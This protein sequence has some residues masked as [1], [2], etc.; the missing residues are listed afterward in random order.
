MAL[1]HMGI[2]V[3]FTVAQGTARVECVADSKRDYDP[4]TDFYKGLRER[5][6]KQFVGGWD[7]QEFR[8]LVREVKTPNKQASYETCRA[9]LT[10]WAQNKDITAS[11][12]PNRN[13]EAAGLQVRV[14]P[15]L[16][17]TIDEKKYVVKLYFKADELTAS[18][19]ENALYLLAETAPQGVDAAILDIR[20]RKL[21]IAG[22]PD[23]N[24]DALLV[25]DAAA[26]AT[27]LG[28]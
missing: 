5:T 10:K 21:L 22:E 24:L 1:V 25:S 4:R 19:R 23:P 12:A 18:R 7:A 8:R 17:M 15:E 14:N 13:W 9:N 2:F 27:L 20:R 28:A 3:E 11:K 26:F 16:R 6:I